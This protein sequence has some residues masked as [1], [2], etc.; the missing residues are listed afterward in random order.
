MRRG[1]GAEGW[2]KELWHPLLPNAGQ[3]TM[4]Y[5]ETWDIRIKSPRALAHLFPYPFTESLS[6]RV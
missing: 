4:G 1:A 5:C 3:F 6:P 2:R